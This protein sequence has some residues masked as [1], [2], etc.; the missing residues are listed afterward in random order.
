MATT[1]DARNHLS[2]ARR[3]VSGS[4]LVSAAVLLGLLLVAATILLAALSQQP[5]GAYS[6]DLQALSAEAGAVL[7]LLAG[8]LALLNMM[9]WA[10]VAS[11]AVLAAVLWAPRRR[12]LLGFAFLNGLF[13]LDD[14]LLL[15][16]GVGPELGLP[17]QAFYLLYGTIGVLLLVCAFRPTVDVRP[18][19]RL[20]R[21]RVQNLS[22]GGR[23]FI[24]GL[25]L[26]GVSVVVDQTIHGQPLWEDAPKLLG[27]FVWL[28]V[29]VLELP[30]NLLGA[31][32][33]GTAAVPR[34]REAR[35]VR[36][37]DDTQLVRAPHQELEGHVGDC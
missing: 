14:A 34:F 22:A 23:A 3:P 1:W 37:H 19:Y 33:S 5:F 29:P 28:T 36:R 26:L 25:L 20:S 10:S 13:A 7:P 12:W 18:E 16:D 6:R 30:S 32:R 4:F 35:W 31:T 27:A 17:E 24:L 8:G 15:H 11:M 9:V 2:S 21:F